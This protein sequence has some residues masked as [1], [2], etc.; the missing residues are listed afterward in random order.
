MKR[1]KTVNL[2]QQTKAESETVV[3]AA[4]ILARV[5]FLD[6]L[7]RLSQD[8]GLPLPKGATIVIPTAK[9]VYEKGGMAL[10]SQVAKVHFKTTKAVVGR[11]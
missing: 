3:A 7:A 4:S 8:C 6:G 2:L 5:G 9:K 10:L 1:G 11:K